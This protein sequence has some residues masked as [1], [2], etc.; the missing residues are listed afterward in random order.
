MCLTFKNILISFPLA[1]AGL[2]ASVASPGQKALTRARLQ[3]TDAELERCNMAE[4]AMEGSKGGRQMIRRM[5]PPGK[6]NDYILTVYF[7]RGMFVP[8]GR[9]T[10]WTGFEHR[11]LL[12]HPV[13]KQ[14]ILTESS[15]FSQGYGVE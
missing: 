11:N 10:N 2:Y 12:L 13:T 4:L 15:L 5:P 8:T 9:S 14:V 3:T 7:A 1:G 6:I